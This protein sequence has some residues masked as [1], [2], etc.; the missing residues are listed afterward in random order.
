MKQYTE[1]CDHSKTTSWIH[2]AVVSQIS[3]SCKLDVVKHLQPIASATCK[4]INKLVHSKYWHNTVEY[5]S[6]IQEKKKYPT[7][8]THQFEN[9]TWIVF[10]V[11]EH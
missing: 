6:L 9:D 8:P 1:G 10:C 4:Y 5:T 11:S 2:P 3:I 7:I